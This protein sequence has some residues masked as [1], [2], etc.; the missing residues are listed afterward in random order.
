M[1]DVI[2]VSNHE[3]RIKTFI[4]YL[5]T[6][7]DNSSSNEESKK[8]RYSEM[9]YI[10][11]NVKKAIAVYPRSDELGSVKLIYQE[12]ARVAMVEYHNFSDFLLVIAIDDESYIYQ[13]RSH[14]QISANNNWF[15][16]IKEHDAIVI[17]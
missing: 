6:E 17:K 1:I 10:I 8:E 15:I 12:R 5:R 16:V 2:T 3:D 11:A 7:F 14:F 9:E 13:I 4:E